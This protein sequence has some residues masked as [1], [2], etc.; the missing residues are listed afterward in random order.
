VGDDET[1]SEAAGPHTPPQAAGPA[2]IRDRLCRAATPSVA[3][4]EDQE[5]SVKKLQHFLHSNPAAVP[6][7]VL[8]L[9]L[10]IFGV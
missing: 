4:F 6:L 8:V 10:V 9:A 3:S 1:G 5:R 2:G 7:I